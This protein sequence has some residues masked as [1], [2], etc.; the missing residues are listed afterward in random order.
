MLYEVRDYAIPPGRSAEIEGRML[1][2]VPPLFRAHGIRAVAHWT[3]LSG[4]G[5]PRF[6]YVLEWSDASA[7]EAG[8]ARFYADERWWRVRAETNAGSELVEHYGLWLTRANAATPA[9][10]ATLPKPEDEALHELILFDVAIGQGAAVSAALTR[11][12]L[13]AVARHGG[14]VTA[15]LDMVA[16]PRIPSLALFL[17]WPSFA[18]R[19][20]GQAAAMSAL[21]VEAALFGRHDSTLLRPVLEP[22]A[23]GKEETGWQR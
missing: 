12:I 16:G 21:G 6:L 17:T 14:R 15:A 13:P 2:S 4:P 5:L 18:V 9:P 10:F 11:E 23:H 3:A 20:A 22:A 19:Q 7:R 8:W 1:R